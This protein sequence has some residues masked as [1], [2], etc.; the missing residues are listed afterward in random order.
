[1]AKETRQRTCHLRFLSHFMIVVTEEQPFTMYMTLLLN[2]ASVYII[3]L[4]LM[5]HPKWQRQYQMNFKILM[6]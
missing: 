1:M 2:V 4:S 6:T 3:K 5:C